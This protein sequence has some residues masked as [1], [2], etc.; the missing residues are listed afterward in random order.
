MSMSDKYINFIFQSTLLMRGATRENHHIVRI[1]EISIHAPHAR[2]DLIRESTAKQCFVI[3]IHAPHARSDSPLIVPRIPRSRFQSTLLM[4]GARGSIN[5]TVKKVKDFNPRSSC[6][7]RRQ[8]PR[9]RACHRDFNP[10]SS[11]EER[12]DDIALRTRIKISI[13]AP[14]ARSDAALKT[15]YKRDTEFQSTLLMRGATAIAAVAAAIYFVFQS[16][17]L[18]RGA[19]TLEEIQAYAK[20]FQSTLLMRGA[21]VEELDELHK[22]QI[23]IHAPHA[24]SDSLLEQYRGRPL[25][26]I[27][28]PHARSDSRAADTRYLQQISIHAPHARSDITERHCYVLADISIHAPHARSD[29]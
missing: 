15:M 2:S 11:C 8:K 27:H 14:H 25:I 7:E 29:F 18:M 4:R 22:E 6:E 3:S 24:R 20:E 1:V 17:L 5:G 12:P 16:T 28:A 9:R 21:T 19:T 13:H 26:S 23:S 10:R